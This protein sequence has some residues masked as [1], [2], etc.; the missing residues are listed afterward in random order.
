MGERKVNASNMLVSIGVCFIGLL[1]YALLR[2]FAPSG[3]SYTVSVSLFVAF[4]LI[5]IKCGTRRFFFDIVLTVPLV[6]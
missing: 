1:T 2:I 3:F 4:I 5:L 6:L